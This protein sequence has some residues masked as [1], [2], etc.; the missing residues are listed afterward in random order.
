[1][2]VTDLTGAYAGMRWLHTVT[3]GKSTVKLACSP[4]VYC[5]LKLLKMR[6]TIVYNE[7]FFSLVSLINIPIYISHRQYK[8]H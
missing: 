5:S 4:A 7:N 2:L 1:M 6:N 3:I 8:T